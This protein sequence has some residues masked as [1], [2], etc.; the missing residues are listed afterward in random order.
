MISKTVLGFA[1]FLL[2]L[3]AV[4]YPAAAGTGC[5]SNWLGSDS[6]DQDFWVSK[7]QNQGISGPNMK[8]P[9]NSSVK[10]ELIGLVP[11]LLSPQAPGEQVVWTAEATAPQ[12]DQLRY[13]FLLKGPSTEG[14]T[15]DQTGWTANNTWVWNTG[16]ADIG[17]NQIEVRIKYGQNLDTDGFDAS[18][19]VTFLI[20]SP[21]SSQQNQTVAEP[22]DP[23]PHPKFARTQSSETVLSKP[24]LAPDERPKANPAAGKVNM[25]M[26]DPI[27]KTVSTDDV[28]T[29][30]PVIVEVPEEASGPEILQVGGKWSVRLEGSAGRSLDLILIQNGEMIMGSGNLN[31]GQ[32]K[33]AVTASGSISGEQV[34]LDVKTV[35]SEYGNKIDKRYELDLTLADGS[36]AGTYE[37]YDGEDFVGKGNA[38]A[39]KPGFA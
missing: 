27:P 31:D 6:N 3:A 35:V 15:L 2:C 12:M 20:A 36:M 29:T 19:T 5:G 30:A 16:D 18:K 9:D 17:E 4:T 10:P 32:N 14:A 25:S 13:K 1:A 38:T 21:G 39:S 22:I 8:M 34:A 37:Q 33:I 23:N 26:P 11:D 7:N 28:E 24:R